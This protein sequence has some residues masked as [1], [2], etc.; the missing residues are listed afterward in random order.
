MS[1]RP[2]PFDRADFPFALRLVTEAAAVAAHQWVGRSRKEDG[3]GAAVEAMRKALNDININAVVMIGE[4][5]KDNAPLLY[6]GEQLLAVANLPE[7][8]ARRL[9]TWARDVDRRFRPGRAPPL[10]ADLLAQVESHLAASQRELLEELRAGPAALERKRQ[11]I[12]E[13]RA[14]LEPDLQSARKA[15]SAAL[16]RQQQ[17]GSQ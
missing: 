12:E 11:E 1:T 7:L 2:G 15:L 8:S 3:D 16:T 6:R 9:T 14:A 10:D 5:E 4:G 13:A 17:E